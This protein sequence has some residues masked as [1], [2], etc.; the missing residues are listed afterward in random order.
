MVQTIIAVYVHFLASLPTVPVTNLVSFLPIIQTKYNF[1]SAYF[2]VYWLLDFFFMSFH[3]LFTSCYLL[4]DLA[5]SFLLNL[6]SLFSIDNNFLSVK[7]SLRV[8]PDH[9]LVSEVLKFYIAKSLTF[10]LMASGFV[11]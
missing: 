10:F 3:C 4:F 1:L 8:S 7:G 2:K 6:R 9:L 5:L 11:S